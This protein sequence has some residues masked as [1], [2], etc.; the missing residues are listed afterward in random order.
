MPSVTDPQPNVP[1]QASAADSFS[2]REL[3]AR[4]SFVRVM[5][6]VIIALV[7]AAMTT[8]FWRSFILH[9]PSSA[10][11]VVGDQTLD[12]AEIVVHG[13]THDLIA[14]LDADNGFSTPIL[15]DPGRYSMEVTL[16]NHVIMKTDFTVDRLR[17][18][19]YTLPCAVPIIGV[20]G[21][22]DTEV[23]VEG[24]TDSKKAVKLDPITL[25]ADD[26]FRES[27]FLSAGAYRATASQKGRVISVHSFRVS[28]G[29]PVEVDVIDS[30]PQ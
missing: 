1:Q 21:S 20:S 5:T 7:L 4:G 23:V 26:H 29:V 19:Q 16:G 11:I 18:M 8:I 12:G 22:G 13:G 9:E 10:V 17:G 30:K 3:P 2:E 14:S 15:L 24:E 25:D 27:I 6:A 28:R